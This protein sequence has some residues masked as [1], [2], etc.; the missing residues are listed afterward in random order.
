MLKS[1]IFFKVLTQFLNTEFTYL[2]YDKVFI[3]FASF[4]SKVNF[5]K[6]LKPKFTDTT[7]SK[8]TT[9]NQS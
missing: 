9:L 4:Q 6:S 8:F 1:V 5:S 7:S 3:L 2:F